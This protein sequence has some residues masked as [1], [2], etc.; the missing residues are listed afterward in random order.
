MPPAKRPPAT[1]NRNQARAATRRQ[2]PIPSLTDAAVDADA[3]AEVDESSPL[4]ASSPLPHEE[5]SGGDNDSSRDRE[6]N[7]DSG[8]SSVVLSPS[9]V[10]REMKEAVRSSVFHSL[11]F[12]ANPIDE[13]LPFYTL[14]PVYDGAARSP[15]SK[16]S[17]T[18]RRRI[19]REQP[20]I[21]AVYSHIFPFGFLDR[22]TS[23]SLLP[24]LAKI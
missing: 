23:S 18:T 15:L 10:R 12:S 9:R 16:R 21:L 8:N 11:L 6:E 7:R 3:E 5:E 17:R 4:R 1:R 13:S 20:P 19:R 24:F 2:P 22:S 14:C